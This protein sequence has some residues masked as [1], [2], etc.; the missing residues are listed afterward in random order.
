MGL[1]LCLAL[2][3]AELAV[4][5]AARFDETPPRELRPVRGSGAQIQ[6]WQTVTVPRVRLLIVG[7]SFTF[8]YGVTARQAYPGQLVTACNR[9]GRG[10]EIISYSRPGWNTHRERLALARDFDRIDPDVLILGHCLNDA[11]YLITDRMLEQRPE[12]RPWTPAAGWERRLAT[13]S[14]LYRRFRQTRDGLRLRPLLRAY[15]I[16]LYQNGRGRRRWQR[17]L[18]RIAASA[19]QRR[20]PAVLVSFPVFDSELDEEYAYRDLHRAVSEAGTTAGFR[21]LDLLS[22]Y[23]GHRGRDLALEPYTDP[24]PSALAHAIAAE[25]IAEFLD[26]NDLLEPRGGEKRA[27]PADGN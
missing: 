27:P 20:V 14:I 22:V 17:S 25:A 24:H 5:V 23:D 16:G 8:G 18:R 4:R 15:Y 6:R 2:L 9:L 11:E 10:V 21:V 3:S 7:D 13:H 19:R 1:G 26:T 12:L